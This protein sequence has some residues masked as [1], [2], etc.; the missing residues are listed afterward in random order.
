M[1]IRYIKLFAKCRFFKWKIISFSFTSPLLSFGP[2]QLSSLLPPSPL[3]RPADPSAKPLP[4]PLSSRAHRWPSPKAYL[5]SPL[6]LNPSPLT[7]LPPSL[8]LPHP[9]L[10][11]SAPHPPL[12]AHPFPPCRSLAVPR[13]PRGLCAPG[14]R[15]HPPFSTHLPTRLA[16]PPCEPLD[17]AR[18]SSPPAPLLTRS[19]HPR[20]HTI[21]TAPDPTVHRSLSPVPP[22]RLGLTTS[23]SAPC[24]R[25]SAPDFG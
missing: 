18:T 22:P 25:L 3:T 14:C 4:F 16:R 10:P 12:H 17:A 7:S 19:L 9:T 24:A 11:P 8:S 1:Y 2:A 21:L 5:A 13:A 20:H 6:T 15:Q 23:P